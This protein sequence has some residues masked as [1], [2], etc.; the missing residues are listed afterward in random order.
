MNKWDA[1]WVIIILR[2]LLVISGGSFIS[3]FVDWN[4][5][6]VLARTDCWRMSGRHPVRVYLQPVPK[7]GSRQEGIRWR[8][9]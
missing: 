1:H 5:T 3:S 2:H 4:W 8:W 6:G 7:L 9:R